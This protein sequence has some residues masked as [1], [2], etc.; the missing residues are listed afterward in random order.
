MVAATKASAVEVR[1]TPRAFS[2]GATTRVIIK[3]M[4]I[5]LAICVFLLPTV[6]VAIARP[7]E[8]LPAAEVSNP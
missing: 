3:W 1:H 6:Y 7:G 4:G 2:Q 5:A 8:A